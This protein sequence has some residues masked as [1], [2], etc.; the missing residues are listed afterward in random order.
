MSQRNGDRSLYNRKRKAKIA[1][2]E[3]N[4]KIRENLAKPAE[5]AAKK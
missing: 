2:R 5:T 3:K 1:L 4:R